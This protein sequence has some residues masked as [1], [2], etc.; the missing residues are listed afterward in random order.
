MG[1]GGVRGWLWLSDRLRFRP[2]A[3]TTMATATTSWRASSREDGRAWAAAL[4]RA[5][6]SEHGNGADAEVEGVCSARKVG[7]AWIRH[8]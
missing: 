2:E 6:A 4:R 8:G 5:S 3:V 7:R 1:G